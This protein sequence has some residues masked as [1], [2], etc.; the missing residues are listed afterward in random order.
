[1]EHAV[2]FYYDTLK[3][4]TVTFRYLTSV[5]ASPGQNNVAI[6]GLHHTMLVSCYNL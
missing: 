5:D 6:S 3:C 4:N 2:T 1:M